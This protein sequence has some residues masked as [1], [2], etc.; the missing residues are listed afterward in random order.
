MKDKTMMQY[1]SEIKMKC[2]A[3][4]I[5]GSLLSV[6]DVILYTLNRLSSTYQAFKMSIRTNLQLIS[7]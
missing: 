7:L 2:D 3:N 5:S 6:E 1:Q 4:A